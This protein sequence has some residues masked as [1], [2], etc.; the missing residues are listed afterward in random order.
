MV[1]SIQPELMI[2]YLTLSCSA[3][4]EWS[5]LISR[6]PLVG[7]TLIWKTEPADFTIGIHVNGTLPSHV[8]VNSIGR[9]NLSP[10]FLCL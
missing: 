4:I 7:F 5:D 8:I 2:I 3:A 9:V 1:A 6:E 10:K